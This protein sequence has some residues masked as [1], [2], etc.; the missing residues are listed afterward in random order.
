MHNADIGN[1]Q[2]K[3]LRRRSPYTTT[4]ESMYFRFDGEELCRYTVTVLA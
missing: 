4:V 2:A 1:V 3:L